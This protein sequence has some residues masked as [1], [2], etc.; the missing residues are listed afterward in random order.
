[1]GDT[2]GQYPYI[3]QFGFN[4]WGM[5]F[6]FGDDDAAWFRHR[7]RPRRGRDRRQ[8]VAAPATGATSSGLLGV[9][10]LIGLVIYFL[11]TR[12]H[13]RYLYGAIAFLPRWRWSSAACAGRSSPL[14]LAVLRHRSPTC[15]Q[16]AVPIL[17]RRADR[18]FPF[19]VISAARRSVTLAG[20][21]TA[22]RI[23]E[24]FRIAGARTLAA[25]AGS[26]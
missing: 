13:E 22:W 16:L 21:W 4:P 8:P 7:D 26:G 14:S 1:M 20:A 23:V 9:S 11:P 6:G 10:V 19:W 3:S 2:F 25:D 12:V 5:V 17:P 18:A 15:C 24:L